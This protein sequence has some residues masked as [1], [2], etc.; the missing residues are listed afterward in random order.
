MKSG[1][2]AAYQKVQEAKRNARVR[3]TA[4][5]IGASSTPPY[6]SSVLGTSSSRPLLVNLIHTP[7]LPPAPV[8]PV[9][10]TLEPEKKKR[11]T[12]EAG[13]SSVGKADFDVPS[14]R[15]STSFPIARL[16]WMMLL[17]VIIFKF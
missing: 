1:S 6:Q 5:E 4:Q 11:K 15:E 17:F 12:M 16:L 7:P 10:P 14:L 2:K 9:H 3:A 13:V 8:P